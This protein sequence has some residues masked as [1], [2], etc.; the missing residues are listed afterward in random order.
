MS[1]KITKMNHE[2]SKE[3]YTQGFPSKIII[4]DTN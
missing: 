3:I 2:G 4:D 1:V